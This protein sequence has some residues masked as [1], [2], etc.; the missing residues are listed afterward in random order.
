M[1]NAKSRGNLSAAIEIVDTLKQR[2]PIASD[3]TKKAQDRAKENAGDN[4]ATRK[5]IMISNIRSF[6]SS[7]QFK[8]KGRRKEIVQNYL[9]AVGASLL[10]PSNGFYTVLSLASSGNF[11]L[12]FE[13]CPV[14]E[15]NKEYGTFKVVTPIGYLYCSKETLVNFYK[16]TESNL[17][18]RFLHKDFNLNQQLLQRCQSHRN[19]LYCGEKPFNRPLSKQMQRW[20]NFDYEIRDAIYCMGHDPEYV[21][22]DNYCSQRYRCFDCNGSRCKHFGR[23]HNWMINGNKRSQYEIFLDSGHFGQLVSD[24]KELNPTKEITTELV[25]KKVSYRK[26]LKFIPNCVKPETRASCVNPI[27]APA[28]DYARCLQLHFKGLLSK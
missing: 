9:E 25:Q 13:R 15:E 22:P 11:P 10:S 28:Y 12:L 23:R 5:D 7:A 19:I 1:I 27:E 2:L 24:L 20:D 18:H 16:Q 21:R 8:T 4:E 26:F 6:L 17:S 3:P 14:L